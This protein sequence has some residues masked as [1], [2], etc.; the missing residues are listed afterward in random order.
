LAEHQRLLSL[1]RMRNHLLIILSELKFDWVWQLR[2]NLT[3]NSLS[4]S[5][6]DL[7]KVVNSILHETLGLVKLIPEL[8]LDSAH[9]RPSVHSVGFNIGNLILVL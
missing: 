8:L 5:R 4:M 7:S 1:D 3:L 6:Y 2:N 9:I